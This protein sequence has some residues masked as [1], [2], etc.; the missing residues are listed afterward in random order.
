MKKEET[1][2]VVEIPDGLETSVTFHTAVTQAV[3]VS[4]TDPVPEL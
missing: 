3:W 2:E 1:K 4:I